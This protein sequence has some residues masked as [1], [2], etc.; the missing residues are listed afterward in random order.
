MKNTIAC[1]ITISSSL[2]FGCGGGSGATNTEVTQTTAAIPPAQNTSTVQQPVANSGITQ[3]V[4]VTTPSEPQD[5]NPPAQAPSIVSMPSSAVASPGTKVWLPINLDIEATEYPVTVSYEVNTPKGNFSGSSVIAQGVDGCITF[6]IDDTAN[7]GDEW[8]VQ[9][10]SVDNAEVG[11]NHTSSVEVKFGTAEVS[12]VSPYENI[13]NSI[14]TDLAGYKIY[15]GE[16]AEDLSKVVQVNNPTATSWTIDELTISK[17]FYF[18][19]SVINEKGIESEL[20]NIA[21][22]YIDS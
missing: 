4:S 5:A 21:E 17:E 12:W 10:S 19:V 2:L 1:L 14:L 7:V 22:K 3:P 18:A 11:K 6:D 16:S 8:I 9:I 15:Y 20:S 13:D